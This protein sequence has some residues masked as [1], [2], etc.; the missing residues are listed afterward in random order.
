[1]LLARLASR[2]IGGAAEQV[3]ILAVLPQLHIQNQPCD[4][5]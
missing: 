3:Q 1:M 4:I 5:P 2:R